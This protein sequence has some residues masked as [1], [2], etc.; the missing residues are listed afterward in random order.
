MKLESPEKS[1]WTPHRFS[2]GRLVLDICNTVIL[3]HDAVRSVD[4]FASPEQLAAFPAAAVELGAESWAFDDLSGEIGNIFELREVADRGQLGGEQYRGE[5]HNI[6]TPE[7]L[8]A[9]NAPLRPFP[10]V[11]K[12]NL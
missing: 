8:A 4:R 9:L 7:Q 6:G 5:W 12:E 3:R 1:A 2:G 11:A 10:K